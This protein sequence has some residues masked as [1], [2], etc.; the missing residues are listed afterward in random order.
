MN[1]WQTCLTVF[2]VAQRDVFKP[3]EKLTLSE[4]ADK[5]RFVSSGAKQG[6][7]KTSYVPYMKEIQ[8]AVSDPEVN[9][10]TLMFS[11]QV[12]KSELLCNTIGYYSHLEPTQILV[13]Q[14]SENMAKAF[15][16][17]RIKTMVK[18]SKVLRGLFKLN[19]DDGRMKSADTILTKQFKGGCLNLTGSNSPN[20]LSSRAIQVLLLDE[21][22]RY[23]VDGANS[24]GDIISQAVQRTETYEFRAKVIK[25][26]TP[27]DKETSVIY[28]E[29]LKGT[30]GQWNHKCVH[31]QDYFAPKIEH[32][33][34]VEDDPRTATL[35]CP[36]CGGLHDNI[37]RLKGMMEGRWVHAFPERLSKSFHLNVFSSPFTS[38]EKIAEKYITSR[39]T[40]ALKKAFNNLQLGLPDDAGISDVAN[41]EFSDQIVY[42]K[43][44]SLPNDCYV[45]TMTVDVQSDRVEYMTTAFREGG[46]M[47]IIDYGS[48]L[49]E[50]SDDKVKKELE[51][52]GDRKFKLECG[53]E[54]VV[55]K[56]GIDSGYNTFA[57]LQMVRALKN[58]GWMALKGIAGMNKLPITSNSIESKTHKGFR[59]YQ[60]GS[61]TNKTQ[62]YN[63][64]KNQKIE[65]CYSDD[66]DLDHFWKS[67]TAEKQ[68]VKMSNGRPKVIWVVGEHD[69]NEVLDL[70]G[71]NVAMLVATKM[72]ESQL[73]ANIRQQMAKRGIVIKSEES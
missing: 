54:L 44:T 53:L 70:A 71:Y 59:F 60:V 56:K 31:C 72:S 13:V 17:E 21:V 46:R 23:G 40:D 50:I 33:N 30:Q 25:V 18:A 35:A 6:K 64:L 9:E 66:I 20:G 5:Y 61:D 26:S 51:K 69:R 22:D 28:R 7:W 42:H 27:V 58:K 38:L 68:L 43:P 47:L 62:V 73:I 10:I 41:L 16:K 65:V 3:K 32:L 2:K 48:V 55:F 57:V 63:M 36:T 19:D 24:D 14:P 37:Q 45:I 29:Y 67:M 49:G 11:S 15:S 1:D 39:A 34:I 4:W 12:G 52:L 8:D